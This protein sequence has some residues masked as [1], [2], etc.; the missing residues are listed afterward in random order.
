MGREEVLKRKKQRRKTEE[1]KEEKEVEKKKRM[2][3][4]RMRKKENKKKGG[5][6]VKEGERGRVKGWRRANG[7]GGESRKLKGCRCHLVSPE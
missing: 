3:K 6:E 7:H 4:K 2:R 1:K 5:I